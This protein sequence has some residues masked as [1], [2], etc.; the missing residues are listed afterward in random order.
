MHTIVK[1]A[2]AVC[3]ANPPHKIRIFTF[4]N[5]EIRLIHF[6]LIH[7]FRNHI[8]VSLLL[9]FP[10]SSYHDPTFPPAMNHQVVKLTSGIGVA[11][12]RAHTRVPWYVAMQSPTL[13]LILD[14][15]KS[16]IDPCGVFLENITNSVTLESVTPDALHQC[17]NFLRDPTTA[18]PELSCVIETLYAAKYL[19]L[20]TLNENLD[21]N[22]AILLMGHL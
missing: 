22:V 5:P 3:T 1:Y 21:E 2:V 16:S 13:Q 12:L 18:V 15:G 14:R 4:Q 9:Q 17:V 19:E 6:H 8:S 11:G 20:G 7:Y 10:T